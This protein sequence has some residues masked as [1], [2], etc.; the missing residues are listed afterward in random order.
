MDQ[1]K[2]RRRLRIPS[3]AMIVACVALF[4]ALGGTSYAAV[5]LAANSVGT[6][7][8]KNGAVTA[9]KVGKVPGARVK[10]TAATTVTSG[11]TAVLQWNATDFNVGSVYKA[12]K[13]DRLTAPV[14]GRYLIVASVR[15]PY[16]TT[17]RRALALS[18]NGTGNEIG[19]SNVAPYATTTLDAQQ[20]V[21]AVYRLKAGDYVQVWA[22][23]DSGSS[24]GLRTDVVSGVTFTMQWMAP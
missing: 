18:L 14:A 11:A 23:Q 3:P 22:Y 12:T 13:K 10:D 15:W 17:G 9:A 21:E 5:T 7:Q 4:V 8:L 19:L 24:L 2:R 6:K 16:N 20:T 1:G